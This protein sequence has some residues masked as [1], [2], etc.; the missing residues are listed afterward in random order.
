MHRAP[1]PLAPLLT[2]SCLTVRKKAFRKKN[3]SAHLIV[4]LD[5]R[6]TKWPES[7]RASPASQHRGQIHAL[8]RLDTAVRVSAKQNRKALG[9][10]CQRHRRKMLKKD[11]DVH[12]FHR[13][14]RLPCTASWHRRR[15]HVKL[16]DSD[17]VRPVSTIAADNRDY[18]VRI[19]RAT[20]FHK[21]G[22]T[23]LRTF[24]PRISRHRSATCDGQTETETSEKIGP[25]H[26]RD[27]STLR[28]A[29]P[30]LS[31]LET[32][33]GARRTQSSSKRCIKIDPKTGIQMA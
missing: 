1:G 12:I 22:C 19:R 30:T 4:A 15:H 7:E 11:L 10:T 16:H 20:V 33:S 26:G 29:V 32:T 23:D 3:P 21:K 28:P 6:G 18:A 25:T 27:Y 5:R 24:G 13:W 17:Q 31:V 9:D 14:S 2:S 8:P